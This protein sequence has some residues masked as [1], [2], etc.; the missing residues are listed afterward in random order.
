MASAEKDKQ[1][2]ITSEL[3]APAGSLE[4]FFAALEAGADAMYCGL[5]EFSA[6][7]KAKNFTLAEAEKL[8]RIAHQEK[9]KLF[10]AL[11][12][13]IKEKELPRLVEVLAHLEMI[14]VD[15][16]ILQ[17]FGVC[18]L[19]QAHFPKL[20]LHASTQMGIHN[21]A[22]VQMLEKLGFSRAVL[23]RELSLDEI[24][25][26]RKKSSIELEHFVH[27]A[28]CFCVSG[29]CLFSS[30]LTG[31][32]GNRGQCAQPCR[33]RYHYKKRPGYYFSPNDFCALDMI[34]QLLTAGVM[35][36]KIEG[37]MK[38]AEYVHQVVTA[39]RL[40][41][42]STAKN[43]KAALAEAKEHLAL[44]FGRQTT[45]GFLRGS[46][47]GNITI[48]AKKGGIGQALGLV[49]KARGSSI[50]L[51]PQ[52]KIYVG[53]RIRI[54]PKSDLAGSGFVVQKMLL[55]GKSVKSVEPG[56]DVEVV[57]PYKKM[58]QPGDQVLK[59]GTGKVKIP[60]REACMRRLKTVRPVKQK[61][62]LRLA[63]TGK[64]LRIAATVH[65]VSLGRDFE[66]GAGDSD[67]KVWESASLKK[68]FAKSGGRFT[69]GL[70]NCKGEAIRLSPAAIKS[71]RD[72][73]YDELVRYLEENHKQAVG[74]KI[75]TAQAALFGDIPA[76]KAQP[77]T[78]LAVAIRSVREA[79]I[80]DDPAVHTVIVPLTPENVGTYQKERT[81]ITVDL[82]QIVWD[83]PAILFG[84]DWQEFRQVIEQLYAG[85]FKRFRLNN[86][87][88][89]PLFAGLEQVE[90]SG[91][92]WLYSTNSQAVRFWLSQGV[93]NLC[94]SIEDDGENMSALL[95]KAKG[96]VTVPLFSPIP[97]LTSRI[98]LRGIKPGSEVE[99]DKGEVFRVFSRDGLTT[100]VACEDFSICAE[101]E[102]LKQNGATG[103][104]LDFSRCGATSKRGQEV[105]QGYKE[106]RDAEK[107]IPLN[108]FRGLV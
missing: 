88:H 64:S 39:Y 104:L 91:G 3:L 33:R 74:E 107:S 106:K 105:L 45:S 48:A 75:R 23:A 80:L 62:G 65:G 69:L 56:Q 46:V 108:Y 54:Q 40:V 70:W 90:L 67:A 11:N 50:I 37:R 25:E 53:D 30:Y 103:F 76:G 1:R 16:I 61:I 5:S 10:I 20:P 47:P 87:G 43:R 14:G 59:V 96:G 79:T 63:L 102:Q 55:K 82:Q 58:F 100:V 36:L 42:D 4:S 92:A 13:L 9:R 86:L 34:P 52:E 97:V 51:S 24:T 83:V 7:A 19:A 78:R 73:F 17:D 6:R 31:R 89:F 81:K 93:R 41:L 68:I 29:Q 71:L 32:S 84:H 95:A 99:S 57:T 21:A 12:T 60:G 77:K 28:L 38:S 8:C 22:G 101:V 15:G 98:P 44:S 35:S 72:R 66:M 18:Q 27:G 26:I 85:G 94:L 2:H 49:E